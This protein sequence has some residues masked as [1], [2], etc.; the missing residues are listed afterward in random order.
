MQ[1][2]QWSKV[3]EV[4]HEALGLPESERAAFLISACGPNR[5]LIDE[6][7]AMLAADSQGSS[8]LD[9]GLPDIAYRMVGNG[10]DSIPS[11][12]FGP[13]RLKRILGEGGMGVVWLAERS[14]AGN[15]VAIKFL[16][17]AG[18]TPARRE[19]FAREIRTLAKLNHPLIARL[20]DAGTLSDG[21]PWFVMEYVEGVRL[22]E[23]CRAPGRT[24]EEQ[25]RAFRSVCGAV[26]Y[27]HGQEII[28]R[29]LKPS[30]ILIAE[31]GAPRLLDFGIAR[32]LHQLDDSGEQTRPG[33]RFLSPDYAAPE[34]VREGIV[35]LYT[36]VYSLG[37]VLYEML[38]GRLPFERSKPST[39][40]SEERS[41]GHHVDKPSVVVSRL[42]GPE[43]AANPAARLSKS[44]WA[45][46]DVLCL[47]AM[48]RDA[49]ERYPSV[50]ALL[51]DIDH[52]LNSEP[53]EARPD[54][55]RYRAGKFVSRHRAA[56]LAVSLTL[57]LVACMAS[58]FTYRLAKA[59]S[60]ALAEAAR[61][62]RIQRFML[63]MLGSGD[64]EA[65]P[66]GDLRVI[67]LLD[68]GAKEADTLDSDPATQA[69]LYETLGNMYDRLGKFDKADNLLSN[70][71]EKAKIAFGPD[72]PKAAE[73]LVAMGAVRGDQSQ[74][75][76][77]EQLAS[78]G[79]ELA[80]RRLQPNDPVLLGAKEALGRV[81]V[82]SG[83]YE[84]AIALLES[85]AQRKPTGEQEEYVVRDALSDLA[86]AEQN[87]Q[88]YDAALPIGLRA[89]AMDRQLLGESHPQTA[90]DMMNLG[91]VQADL[92]EY[93]EAEKNYRGAIEILKNWYGADHPDT[94]TSM[95]I[96]AR[97]LDVEGKSS[98]S[99]AV[100]KD[101]L[102]VQEKS[103][104]KV[105]ERIAFTLDS[106]GRIAVK[107]GDF[108]SAQADFS[109]ALAIDQSLFGNSNYQTAAIQ[110]DLG[111]LYIRKSQFA[112]AESTLRTA[113]A[114]FQ[115]LPGLNPL[116]GLAQARSGRAL[117]GLK[118]YS[119]A[120]KQLIAAQQTME[121][122]HIPPA[123]QLRDVRQD[124]IR[125]YEALNQPQNA[126]KIEAE[127]AA[128]TA[129]E[130]KPAGAK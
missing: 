115:A 123:G 16:P 86:V 45:D 70:A 92:A 5:G 19:R 116:T 75:K 85:I 130:A 94:A 95:V 120:E 23:Y 22:T 68:R 37:V 82:E 18:F 8:L 26:L 31:D 79:V 24:V 6:V 117:F 56:V 102:D 53:L 52:F 106:L 28:H 73:L 87:A 78:Q 21:T 88:H 66:S 98:E 34:W 4:F 59:R 121:K 128:A 14:D 72:S 49:K 110:S 17:H 124:L 111:D 42:T 35:G 96:L 77:A 113:V 20:Y 38:T 118:R 47:K 39:N 54:T 29:D 84:K 74:L 81:L 60:A 51:R 30:N 129:P 61:T 43:R 58:L 25:L 55:L 2:T 27:A 44:A 67:T 57:V 3:Q 64:Q 97:T 41:P 100:L 63:N 99:E 90:F 80:G 89:I 125:V 46:L 114:A 15:L 103:Y 91:S 7:T 65:A 11:Q 126:K 83:F 104:G 76:A 40:G 69:E 71:L 36:D 9:R 101:M 119:D 62:E 50:E 112:L 10:L 109:R 12:E 13:Y 48:H 122:M 93:A 33:L 107:Q 105:H 32:E 1:S 108:A 127:L